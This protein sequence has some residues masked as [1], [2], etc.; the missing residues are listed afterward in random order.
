MNATHPPPFAVGDTLHVSITDLAFGGEG[1]ARHDQFVLFVPFVVPGEEAEVAIT[2]IHKNYARA[3]LTRLLRASPER[4]TPRCRYFG[5][6]GGCQ[7]QHLAY[8]RQ[9]EL[10]QRQII[11]LLRRVAH[12]HDPPVQPTVPCPVPYGYRNRIMVRSQWNGREQHLLLGF[13]QH[14]NRFVVD[15]DHCPIAEPALNEQLLLVR[16]SPPAKGGLKVTLRIPPEGW[17]LPRDSFFQ[18]N[19]HLLP[20]LLDVVRQRLAS[21]GAHH[22]VDAFCGVGFFALSL[23]DQFESFVGIEL[24]QPAIRSATSN[25]SSR[26]IHNGHFLSG[27]VED[28]LPGVVQEL[29]PARTAVLL[30]PPRRGCAPSTLDT[31]LTARPAQIIYVSC[32]PATLARDLNILCRTGVYHLRAL[33]PLDMF[34]Q[35]QHVE[36]V[37]DLRL[38]PHPPPDAP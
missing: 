32:H 4:V 25:A 12:I 17:H 26:K 28:L 21:A 37:A 5:T 15:V 34:P 20:A 6:C 35:T 30:D 1:V 7:Y 31:L 22:L 9:L 33:T 2:H 29:S 27:A 11:E 38:V 13:L 36:C 18:N 10:K 8:P 24:D 3:R 16:Q 19:F 23:A 14:D